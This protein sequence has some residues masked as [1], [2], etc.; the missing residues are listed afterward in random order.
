VGRDPAE[1]EKSMMVRFSPDDL[2]GLDEQ[3]RKITDLGV[4]TA[5]VNLPSPHNADHVQI[6]AEAITRWG[7]RRP[8]GSKPI[9][10]CRPPSAGFSVG[11]SPPSTMSKPVVTD[12]ATFM[13][14]QHPGYVQD[15]LAGGVTYCAQN[16]G[17]YS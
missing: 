2:T 17:G 15:S 11:A 5:I 7:D 10:V 16:R 14:P 1:I 6:V 9:K 3:L 12:P 13:T 4:D 8:G